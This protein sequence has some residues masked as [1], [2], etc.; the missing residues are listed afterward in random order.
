MSFGKCMF[1]SLTKCCLPLKVTSLKLISIYFWSG[2]QKKKRKNVLDCRGSDQTWVVTHWCCFKLFCE[3]CFS[4][5]VFQII[6]VFGGLIF[7][8]FEKMS[9]QWNRTLTRK[10]HAKSKEVIFLI[11]ILFYFVCS[12]VDV[13]WEGRLPSVYYFCLSVEHYVGHRFVPCL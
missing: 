8:L 3:L 7:K 13:L 1:P 5:F 10:K 2:R 4:L 9:K 12:V 11:I 6:P